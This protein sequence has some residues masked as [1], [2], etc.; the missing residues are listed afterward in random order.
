MQH[1]IVVFLLVLIQIMNKVVQN[2]PAL[3]QVAHIHGIDIL[4]INISFSLHPLFSHPWYT[5]SMS[6]SH[7]IVLS[8]TTQHSVVHSLSLSLSLSLSIIYSST[9]SCML[10]TPVS[11][12]TFFIGK[13]SIVV[14]MST[15]LEIFEHV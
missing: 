8:H 5:F 14:R 10:C 3:D 11:R 9:L 7:F 12:V 2:G 4:S 13:Y 6:M 1:N 15:T